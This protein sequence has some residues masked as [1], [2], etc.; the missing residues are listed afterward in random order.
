MPVDPT[1]TFQAE[2]WLHDSGRWI[3]VTVPHDESDEIHEVAPHRG[4]F[5]SVRVQVT[6]G[7]TQ[8]RTS[9]FPDKKSGCFMLP[10]KKA[11]RTAEQIDT[12]DAATIELTVLMD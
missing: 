7:S 1:F 3:F 4:G 9:V 12:G 10:I 2:L 6:I 8:W 5:G 11:V